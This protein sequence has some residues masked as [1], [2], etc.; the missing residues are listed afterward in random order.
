MICLS[1]REKGLNNVQDALT[2]AHF[3]EIRLDHTD[4]TRE[5][6]VS[7]FRSKKDMIATCRLSQQDVDIC[8]KRLYWAIMASR[9]K[10]SVGKR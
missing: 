7:V 3:A 10:K 8:R 9:T 5:E 2:K 1:I 4:L 6:T